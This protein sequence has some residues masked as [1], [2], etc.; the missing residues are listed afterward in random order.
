MSDFFSGF[1]SYYI[2]IAAL[3]GIAFCVILLMAMSKRRAAPAGKPELH[4]HVWDGDLQEYNNPLPRWWMGMFIITILFSLGYLTLYPGLG[5]FAGMLGW[6][7]KG[8]YAA[9]QKHA[10]E[11]YGPLF[12]KYAKQ[13][14]NLIVADKQAHDMGQRLFLTYC[15]QCHGSDARGGK[16]FPNLTDNDWLYG[17]ELQTIRTTIAEGRNGMMPPWGQSLSSA[18]IKDVTYYVLSLSGFPATS[19]QIAGGQKVF[20]TNCA[21]CHGPEA[22]GNPAMGAPNLTDKVWLHGG[23][24]ADVTET[25]TKGRNSHM[26]AHKDLLDEAKINLLAAYVYSLSQEQK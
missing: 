9:E 17:G 16:G 21:A 25:I 14:L 1:W 10:A 6:S 20:A 3:G 7:S 18:E 19:L 12:A 5:S 11:Q 2:A 22:K 26:P 13:D 15:S 24:I 4:G 23:S 8:E